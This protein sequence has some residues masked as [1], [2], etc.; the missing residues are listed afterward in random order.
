MDQSNEN[1]FWPLAVAGRV[2]WI[3]VFPSVLSS[4]LPAVLSGNF[5]GIGSLVLF[6]MYGV[7]E[8][9]G[10]VPDRR[11]GDLFWKNPFL[12]KMN[13]NGPKMGV[14]GHF[15]K[16]YSLVLSR[17]GVYWKYLWPF[18]ILWKPHMWEKSG[19]QVTTKNAVSQSDF[20]I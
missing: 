14:F 2:L 15:R 13:K 5:L 7:R 16:I 10:D 8:L 20:S 17:N 3:R 6:L 4:V 19:F 18:H 12:V 1:L 9:Y 11:Y